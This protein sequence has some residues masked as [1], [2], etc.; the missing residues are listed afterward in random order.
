MLGSV[1][2][3]GR[4]IAPPTN[5]FSGRIKRFLVGLFG[6]QGPCPPDSDMRTT[7]LRTAS[8]WLPLRATTFSLSEARLNP[9][10]EDDDEGSRTFFRMSLHQ[11]SCFISRLTRFVDLARPDHPT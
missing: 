3:Y 7:R 1:A 11:A 10:R 4:H 8:L 6:I 2:E 9:A 5:A